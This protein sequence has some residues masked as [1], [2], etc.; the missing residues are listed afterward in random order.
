MSLGATTGGAFAPADAARCARTWDPTGQLGGPARPWLR[1]VELGLHEGALLVLEELDVPVPDELL[2][3]ESS[4]DG[5]RHV[6]QHPPTPI[7][8]LEAREHR[9]VVHLVPQEGA[10]PVEGRRRPRVTRSAPRRCR[11]RWRCWSPGSCSR[12][13]S[14]ATCDGRGSAGCR[15]TPCGRCPAAT[16]SARRTWCDAMAAIPAHLKQVGSR[17]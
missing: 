12:R 3:R 4:L 14:A 13:G 16:N 8:R 17:R 7:D 10:D 5:R 6:L 2:G 1:Q 11:R 9:R 15:R